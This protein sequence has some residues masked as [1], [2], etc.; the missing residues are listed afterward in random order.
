MDVTIGAREGQA[1]VEIADSGPGIP[2]EERDRAFDRF[3][4]VPGGAAA[5]SGLGL[6][7]AQSIARRHHATITLGTSSRLGGLLV[8]VRFA[9]GG[10]AQ[11][12]RP[13][14]D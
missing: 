4:R 10:G 1:V 2:V 5:G 12:R 8:T 7:I 9:E 3:Y 11:R 14:S 6:A 13:T